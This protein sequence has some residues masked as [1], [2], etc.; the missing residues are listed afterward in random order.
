MKI[1]Q[2]LL[3]AGIYGSKNLR[4]LII[5]V[6]LA[7]LSFGQS[8]PLSR[9][10]T[11]SGFSISISPSSI[12]IPP[13]GNATYTITVTSPT[14]SSGVAFSVTGIP[15]H[16]TATISMESGSVYSLTIATSRL[17]PQGEYVFTVTATSGGMSASANA[18][19]IVLVA[20]S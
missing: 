18:T 1:K 7:Q 11:S 10:A 12:V 9:S 15:P 6:A 4:A 20:P 13:G 19:L 16:S 2:I 17:T 3:S 8:I 14:I 5:V